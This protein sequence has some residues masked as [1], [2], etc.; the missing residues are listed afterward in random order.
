MTG[1]RKIEREESLRAC[2][3]TLVAFFTAID[4]G[5]ASSAID[6]FTDDATMNARGQQLNGRGEIAASLAEREADT[7]RRTVHV[8]TNETSRQNP[9]GTV[10]LDALLV[11]LV[12]DATGA[13]AID[14][15]LI[16]TQ[17]LRR[18]PD[19]WKIASRATHPLHAPSARQSHSLAQ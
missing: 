7:E 10:E 11:L 17:S 2:H 12:S 14:R 1:L 15:V 6:C 8:L 13:Y 4:R 5:R 16:T 18:T 19:G 3:D 9:D